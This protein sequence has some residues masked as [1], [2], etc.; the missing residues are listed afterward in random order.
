MGLFKTAIVYAIKFPIYV[1]LSLWIVTLKFFK[2]LAS[3]NI[4]IIYPG[5]YIYVYIYKFEN[6][7]QQFDSFKIYVTLVVLFYL[8]KFYAQLFL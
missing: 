8:K 1:T 5:T 6:H 4:E 2:W 3:A 7:K